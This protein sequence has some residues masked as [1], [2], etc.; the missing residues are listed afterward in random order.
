MSNE[1]LLLSICVGSQKSGTSWLYKCLENS[2]EVQ[3][4]EG[5]ETN[6]F[7]TGSNLLEYR[8]KYFEPSHKKIFFEASP[9]YLYSEDARINLHSVG[10]KKIIIILRDPFSRSLSHINHICAKKNINFS[11]LSFFLESYPEVIE[12]SK[13][14]LYV[15]KYIQTFSSEN[16]CLIDYADICSNPSFVIKK[17]CSFLNITYSS[18]MVLKSRYNSG[19]TRSSFIYKQIVYLYLNMRKNRFGRHVITFTR[20]LGIRN[21]LI[22]RI[23]DR[24]K[25]KIS[26]L[27]KDDES[28]L[29]NILSGEINYYEKFRNNQNSSKF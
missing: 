8:K 11:N 13:Y 9:L 5:K 23:F 14:S 4:A 18:K 16:V 12:Y 6:Y 28:Y 15:H 26:F 21:T 22:E 2:L 1:G 10:C 20:R 24:G 19:H 27:N 25:R 3:V 17:I 7:L 29:K